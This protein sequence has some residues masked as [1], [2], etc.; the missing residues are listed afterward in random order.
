[1]TDGKAVNV[2]QGVVTGVYQTC[3]YVEN[4]AR[5]CGVRVESTEAVSVGNIVT[6][7]GVLGSTGTERSVTALS[8][9]VNGQKTPPLRSLALRNSALGGANKGYV[10]GYGGIGVNNV[11]LL[12]TTVGAKQNPDPGG[13]YFYVNDG[14]TPGG[15]K[16]VLT[17]AKT[18][19]TIPSA[20]FL[21]VTGECSL[22]SDGK[23]IV[24]PRSQADVLAVM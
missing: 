22:D 5:T 21:T 15:V 3:F 12:V 6:V 17:G 2:G 7:N 20:T 19:I 10:P 1:M 4:E 16:V 18:A 13:A 14:S 23:A 24:R 11:G 9:T 8:V